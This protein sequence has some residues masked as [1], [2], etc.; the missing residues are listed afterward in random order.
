MFSKCVV[1]WCVC[2]CVSVC[3]CVCVCA[4]FS[5]PPLSLRPRMFL[6]YR[7]LCESI[8]ALL[9]PWLRGA[10]SSFGSS[11]GGGVMVVWWWCGGGV[12]V[13]GW[14]DGGVMVVVRWWWCGGGVVVV[15]WGMLAMGN[16]S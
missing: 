2:V 12:V 8:T 1:R 11:D 9:L 5:H 7:L 4:A 3:V 6:R 15:W 16:E 13:V 14:C 10:V